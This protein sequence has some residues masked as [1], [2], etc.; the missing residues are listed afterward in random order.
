MNTKTNILRKTLSFLL[1]VFLIAGTMFTGAATVNVNA[2]ATIKVRIANV[3]KMYTDAKEYLDLIN[4]YRSQNGKKALTMDKTYLE[5]AML[6]AAELSLYVSAYTPAGENGASYASG[7]SDSAEVIGYD[8]PNLNYALDN[9]KKTSDSVLLNSSYKSAGVGIVNVNGK[10]FYS[11]LVSSK[12]PVAVPNSTFDQGT[13]TVA[14]DITTKP[15][16]ISQISP[17]YGTGQSVYCGS[18]LAANVKVTNKNY[19]N[20][21]VYLTSDYAAVNL[22]DNNVFSY[23]N[24]RVYAQYPGSCIMTIMYNNSYDYSASVTIE[25]IG[26]P[27]SECRFSEVPDQVYIGSAITPTVTVTAADGTTLVKG[28]DYNVTYENNVKVGVATIHIEGKG[29]YAGQKRDIRFSIISSGSD[30]GTYFGVSIIVSK[31]SVPLGES[32]KLTAVTTGGMAPINYTYSYAPYGTSE[33]KNIASTTSTTCTFKPP[34]A[35][36]YNVRIN[37]VDTSGKT[38]SKTAMVN[39]TTPLSGTLTVSSPVTVGVKL[40]LTATS[41]G[42]SAP[43]QYQFS[44][45][46]PGASNYSLIKAYSAETTVKYTPSAAGTY[47]FLLT[48]KSNT[49]EV[50]KITKSVTASSSTLVNKSV[51]SKTELDCGNKLTIKAVASNGKAPYSYAY[52]YKKS[53]DSKYLTIKNFSDTASI[54]HKPS[55]AGIYNYCVKVKDSTGYITKKYFTVKVYSELK[56]NSKISASTTVPGKQIVITGAASGG[57]TGYQYA[58]YY[59]HTKATSYTAI[60]NY[61]TSTT[62]NFTLY[63]KGTYNIR[64]KVKD[65]TG[66]VVSKDFNITFDTTLGNMCTVSPTSITGSGTVTIKFAA[67]GGTAPYK[68]TMSY[69]S[70]T[71]QSYTS[72]GSFAALTS[73]TVTANI[74]GTWVFRVKVQD[75][76]GAIIAKSVAVKVS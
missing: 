22:S 38:A 19:P 3:R 58:Y 45:L 20:H 41:K 42:G 31:S 75:A 48:L 18:S 50:A 47:K 70:P 49:G 36:L 46:K 8:M 1:V 40:T 26:K 59:K 54:A 11:L 72:E 73:K 23:S 9:M 21:F 27:F 74:K 25:A 10:K 29:A 13:V 34:A 76:S 53:S 65:A 66:N 51:I 5:N 43:I 63:N 44:V 30:P 61:S 67:K 60:K 68:Y 35:K 17:A 57:K 24:G 39:V 15:D 2:A 69:K 33:W 12:T 32:V 55:A 62:T 6:R 37:A 14:Q 56:N 64:V 71:S 4:T 28:V 16:V 52:L 7:A